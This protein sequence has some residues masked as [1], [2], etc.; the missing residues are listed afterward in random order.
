MGVVDP[1]MSRPGLIRVLGHCPQQSSL[2]IKL[3]AWS[4]PAPWRASLH[5][6]G[7]YPTMDSAVGIFMEEPGGEDEEAADVEPNR[8][9]DSR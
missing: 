9:G 3:G 1:E 5:E 7:W 6:S 4:F 8:E 2:E